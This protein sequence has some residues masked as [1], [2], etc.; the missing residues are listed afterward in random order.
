MGEPSSAVSSGVGDVHRRGNFQAVLLDSL[1]RATGS[2]LPATAWP[3]D[4]YGL[5]ELAE[6]HGVSCSVY[7]RLKQLDQVP[8]DILD[9]FRLSYHR[10]VQWHL[11][12]LRDLDFVSAA[13]ASLGAPWLVIKGP[14]LS[15]VIYQRP[16]LRSY[17]DLDVVVPGS[18]LA[19]ALEL[20]EAAGATVVDRNWTL[21]RTTMRGELNVQLPSGG[22]VDLHWHVLNEASLRRQFSIS[23]DDMFAGA[24]YVDVAGRMVA[25]LAPTDTL[26][27]I[28]L[29]ACM[30]GGNRLLWMKDVEQAVFFDHPDWDDL[31]I[32]SRQ[33]SAGAAVATVLLR[34]QRALSIPIPD[35]VFPALAGG[36]TWPWMVAAADHL[37]P[38]AGAV[39]GPS[40]ARILARAARRGARSSFVELGRRGMAWLRAGTP[41]GAPLPILNTDLGSLSPL[42]SAKGGMADREAFLQAVAEPDPKWP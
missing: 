42:R 12:S 5:F 3:R 21:V 20:L 39:G 32:R 8:P 10:A 17:C 31:V 34:A 6:F 33:W 28:A 14:V 24:R 11:L 25:T 1:A 4:L 7:L 9:C 27:Y 13:F 29:H 35:E 40:A 41:T 18:S 30:T 38:V 37:W 26:A 16:D 19:L 2:V 22:M 23:M 15:E 36:R